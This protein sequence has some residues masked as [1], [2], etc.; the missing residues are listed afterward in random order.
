VVYP[1]IE[2]ALGL[3]AASVGASVVKA[4]IPVAT[5]IALSNALDR[6]RTLESIDLNKARELGSLSLELERCGLTIDQDLVDV[7]SSHGGLIP[8]TI[9]ELHPELKDFAGDWLVTDVEHVLLMFYLGREQVRLGVG[10]RAAN[11][12]FICK[13]T[14]WSREDLT[15]WFYMV[16]K[17][18]V[19]SEHF[20]NGRLGAYLR[21]LKK[22]TMPSRLAWW[23]DV[24][25]SAG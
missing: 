15:N 18:D 3:T 12:E 19:P 1:Y 25:K 20:V 9:P 24:Q 17:I 13:A 11:F 7:A 16:G 8:V 10:P 2:F 23:S 5:G 21:Y 14:K 6:V 22:V 4:A